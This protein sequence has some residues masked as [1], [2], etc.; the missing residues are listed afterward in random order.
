MQYTPP[1]NSATV[2]DTG[3]AADTG[4]KTDDTT[5]ADA[6]ASEKPE[7]FNWTPYLIG[8]GLLILGIGA[9]IMIRKNKA[10]KLQ[11]AT[12]GIR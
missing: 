3:G 7:G 2:A 6:G 1:A 10:A 5:T 9:F 4:A 12:A 8:G 11:H